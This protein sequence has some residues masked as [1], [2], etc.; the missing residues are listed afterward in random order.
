MTFFLG[1]TGSI[2][3]GKSTTAQLFHKRGCPVWDA[4]ACV[5]RLYGKGGAA[6][7]PIANAFPTAIVDDAV[8]RTRLKAWLTK[9]PNDFEMLEKIVHPLVQADRVAFKNASTADVAIFDIPLL[10]ETN[11]QSEFDAVC[12]VYTSAKN[13]MER[14]L[15]RGTMTVEQIELILSRQWP[16]DKKKG[17]SDYLVCTDSH[18]TA[19]K[20]VDAV[21]ND[22]TERQRH[23]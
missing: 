20:D 23:A 15:S 1:L 4:D 9:N 6:V 10:F 3:M 14:L 2:A 11:A 13:Q 8:D 21:L 7:G 16:I 19:E 5:A 12:C 18:D 22:I 17:M